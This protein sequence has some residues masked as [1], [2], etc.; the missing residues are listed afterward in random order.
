[1]SNTA[2]TPTNAG[3][4]RNLVKYYKI[5]G[6]A[7]A[8]GGTSQAYYMKA[9]RGSYQSGVF[10]QFTTITS[11]DDQPEGAIISSRKTLL[12]NGIIANVILILKPL[13]RD[14]ANGR[15]IVSVPVSQLEEVLKENGKLEAKT[16]GQAKRLI[17]DVRPCTK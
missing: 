17:L 1:M 11:T 5:I 7:P 6:P 2:P 12:L 8:G 14:G 10:G 16:V 13:R 4:D 15:A 3:G 9:K